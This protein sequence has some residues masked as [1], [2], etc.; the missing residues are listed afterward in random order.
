MLHPEAAGARSLAHL[1]LGGDAG[2]WDVTAPRDNAPVQSASTP[3]DAPPRGAPSSLGGWGNQCSPKIF[4]T[5]FRRQIAEISAFLWPNFAQNSMLPGD[6]IVA[7]RL[8]RRPGHGHRPRP[9]WSRATRPWWL[10]SW[11]PRRESSRTG[12]SPSARTSYRSDGATTAVAR[13]TLPG[14]VTVPACSAGTDTPLG[15]ALRATESFRADPWGPTGAIQQPGVTSTP[16]TPS[17][18]F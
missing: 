17:Q 14:T 16:M 18:D 11:P 3:P 1:E 8:A 5:P 10:A 9:C 13:A 7:S 2:T 4:W 12:R 15:T 6:S